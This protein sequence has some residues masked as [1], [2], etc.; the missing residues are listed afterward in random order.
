[1]IYEVYLQYLQHPIVTTSINGALLKIAPNGTTIQIKNGTMLNVSGIIY[2]NS[3][4]FSI[5]VDCGSIGTPQGLARK[6][7]SYLKHT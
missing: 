5:L 1:M 2:V 4:L 6:L 7:A 3:D